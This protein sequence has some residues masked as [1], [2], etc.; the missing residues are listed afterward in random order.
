Q[1]HQL[2]PAA[3]DAVRRRC[4]VRH[5]NV[6]PR[7][8]AALRSHRS[9]RVSLRHSGD[10]VPGRARGDGESARVSIRVE[11]GVATVPGRRG[12]DHCADALP[13]LRIV[14]RE[15][16]CAVRAPSCD[17]MALAEDEEREMNVVKAVTQWGKSVLADYNSTRRYR[18][19]YHAE[20]IPIA[21][22]PIDLTR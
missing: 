3:N 19:K 8:R 22:L 2:A 5:R 4:Q 15:Q 10:A 6:A 9:F 21:R 16:E 13:N 7:L 20:P 18:A 12:R 11:H 1:S 14:A 17:E